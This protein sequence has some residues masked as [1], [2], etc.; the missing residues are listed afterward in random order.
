MRHAAGEKQSRRVVS[1][2]AV[3]HYSEEDE[4]KL[5]MLDLYV[6]FESSIQV[7]RDVFVP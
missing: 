3:P 7:V 6:G 2:Y 5:T 1:A 4:P